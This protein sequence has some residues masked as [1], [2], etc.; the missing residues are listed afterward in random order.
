MYCNLN[1]FQQQKDMNS[2]YFAVGT[3]NGF[4]LILSFNFNDRTVKL[5][6]KTNSHQGAVRS[7][8]VNTSSAGHLLISGGEDK[9]LR[10]W[11]YSTE[12]GTIVKVNELADHKDFVK[13]LAFVDDNCFVSG[14]YD[15]KVALRN[16]SD[17]LSA[18]NV[19]KF[20]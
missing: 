19:I 6:N 14:S 2:V 9:F 20:I 15:F 17:L 1:Q 3:Q 12:C 11:S 4:I 8:C 10:L 7:L 5:V 18:S 13:C 16:S